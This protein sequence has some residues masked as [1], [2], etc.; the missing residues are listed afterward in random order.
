[1][2]LTRALLIAN[3]ALAGLTD[4]QIT[5][6]EELSRNDENSVIGTRIGELHGQYDTDVLSVTG[7]AKNQGEKSYDYVKRVLG[8][9]KS[10][11]ASIPSLN[12]TITDLTTKVTD[13]EEKVKKGEGNEVIAQQLKDAQ[14]KLAD[15]QTLNDTQKTTYE[16]QIA[17]LNTQY[18]DAMVNHAFASALDGVKF[19]EGFD[20][21][22]QRILID[23]AKRTILSTS[24]P[25]WNDENGNKVLVFRDA[26][27]NIMLNQANKLNPFTPRELL[28]KELSAYIEPELHTGGNGTSSREG[29]NH[30]TS[31]DIKS[32]KT[33]SEA[34]DII[35]AQLM[36]DGLTRGSMEFQ[37]K[38]TEIW[39]ANKEF[40]NALP[41][42]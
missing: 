28:Q 23:N 3:A 29:G 26:Q 42:Q 10:K 19:K 14:K 41:I 9:Y 12:K 8:D 16:K 30:H 22:V 6:I 17:D 5:A 40:I 38:Q 33:Q 27:G 20:E 2:A 39:N 31:A 11:T 7:I 18:K 32:A 21:N 15:L 34:M 13:L 36:K 1:M 4:E 24:T 37:D 25:D 35:Q